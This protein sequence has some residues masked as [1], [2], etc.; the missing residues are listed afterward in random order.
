M[1]VAWNAYEDA[2][3]EL[4]LV[5]Q[6]ESIPPGNVAAWANANPQAWKTVVEK[7]G[8]REQYDEWKRSKISG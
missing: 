1:S 8:M 6:A 4:R 7:T 2:K 5:R 3:A